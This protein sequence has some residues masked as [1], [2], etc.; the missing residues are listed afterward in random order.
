MPASFAM[1]LVVDQ[2]LAGAEL[3]RLIVSEALLLFLHRVHHVDD[4]AETDK[5]C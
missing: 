5:M 4:I 1:D 3:R 2:S